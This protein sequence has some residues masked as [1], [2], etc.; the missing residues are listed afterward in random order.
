MTPSDSSPREPAA[1][2]SRTAAPAA[3]PSDA[4]DDAAPRPNAWQRT[5]GT[6]SN[7][8]LK[9]AMAASGTALSLFT[10]GHMAGNMQVY[11]GRERF[12]EYARLLRHAGAP[13]LPPNTLLW[14]ARTGLLASAGVHVLAGT[15][16]TV[17]SMRREGRTV[18]GTAWQVTRRIATVV[19]S[20]PRL[21]LPGRPTS[22]PEQATG[23]PMA[24]RRAPFD[25][26]LLPDRSGAPRRRPRGRRRTLPQIVAR[27]MRS[28]GAVL[29][30]FVGYHVLDLTTGTRPAAARSFEHGDAYGN[31][32]SS[33]SRPAVAAFYAA[34]MAALAGHMVHGLRTAALDTGLTGTAQRVHQVDVAAKAVGAVVA[35]GNVSIPVAVQIKVVR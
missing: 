1:R 15:E 20:R 21:A 33:L 19:D 9:L 24:Y 29:G 5:L 11:A 23:T 27:S 2:A 30:L 32:V 8:D 12:N 6:A 26:A 31:L 17:R 18:A 13:V 28:T 16:L 14:V 7:P 35:I 22:A 4:P 34:S 25:G 3:A 10:V